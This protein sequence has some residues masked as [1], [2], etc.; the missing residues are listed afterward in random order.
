MDPSYP[1]AAEGR[2]EFDV[3]TPYSRHFTTWYSRELLPSCLKGRLARCP[4]WRGCYI[5]RFSMS[6]VGV[7][8]IASQSFLWILST[9][10]LL[11][12]HLHSPFIRKWKQPF[13]DAISWDKQELK[14]IVYSAISNGRIWY[15]LGLSSCGDVLSIEDSPTFQRRSDRRAAS[16]DSPQWAKER[17]K[18]SYPNPFTSPPKKTTIIQI[19]GRATSRSLCI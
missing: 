8:S 11:Y 13:S 1:F 18:S 19:G 17:E 10:R 16:G 15:K 14:E 2:H 4:D 7:M 6:D 5:L 3:Q 9:W 12:L